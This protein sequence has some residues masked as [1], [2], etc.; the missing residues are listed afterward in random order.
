M[1]KA[2]PVFKAM[3]APHLQEGTQLQAQGSV[4]I[5]LPDDD[6]DWM[7]M[8]CRI[9][10]H[11]T[12]NVP[13]HMRHVNHILRASELCDKYDLSRLLKPRIQCWI[14]WKIR[15]LTWSRPAHLKATEREQLLV[16]AYRC[17]HS[18]MFS[19]VGRDIIINDGDA[20]V[21]RERSAW[22]LEI[23][24]HATTVLGMLESDSPTN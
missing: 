2:S 24:I 12:S 6:P 19:L 9:A 8:I 3:L 18:A 14:S 4:E 17:R 20:N 21:K 23:S 1:S 16:A 10:H 7:L 5:L 22:S 15:I 13:G 11:A